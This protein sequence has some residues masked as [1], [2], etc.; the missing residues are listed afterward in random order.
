M[1]EEGV[2]RIRNPGDGSCFV[3]QGPLLDRRAVETFDDAARCLATESKIRIHPCWPVAVID[4]HLIVRH[5]EQR[6]SE[7]TAPFGRS[8][9]F[10]LI[11]AGDGAGRRVVGTNKMRLEVALEE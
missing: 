1:N 11:E 9:D 4:L 2:D 7:T 3:P 5:C 6:N 10:R 8:C